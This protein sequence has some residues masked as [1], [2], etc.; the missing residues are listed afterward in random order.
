MLTSW[1]RMVCR[2]QLLDHLPPGEPQLLPGE[3]HFAGTGELGVALAGPCL[4]GLE[5]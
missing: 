4:L 2:S 5:G 3:G 1:A